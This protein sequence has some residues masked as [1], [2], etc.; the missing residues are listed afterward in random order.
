MWA[1]GVLLLE[2]QPRS[3]RETTIA[4]VENL[5]E[6]LILI[7]L[8]QSGCQSLF[9]ASIVAVKAREVA[10]AVRLYRP[11]GLGERRIAY[12]NF[13]NYLSSR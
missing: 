9:D 11:F 7:V 1:L 6:N 4:A 2:L 5:G 3:E 8:P 13:Q 10:A 12:P